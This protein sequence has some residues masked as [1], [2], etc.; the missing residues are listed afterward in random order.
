MY[1]YEELTS[2]GAKQLPGVD[3]D[4]LEVCVACLLIIRVLTLTL[5]LFLI[6]TSPLTRVLALIFALVLQDVVFVGLN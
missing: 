1:T 6:L 4:A 5:T 3:R 2:E